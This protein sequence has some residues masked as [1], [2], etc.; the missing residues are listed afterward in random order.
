[1]A[2]RAPL[3]E[4]EHTLPPLQGNT[5][6]DPGLERDSKKPKQNKIKSREI[7]IPGRDQVSVYSLHLYSFFFVLCLFFYSC[8]FLIPIS[9]TSNC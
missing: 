9:S 2:N 7:K 5:V 4:P 3:M 1:M 6:V 8:P